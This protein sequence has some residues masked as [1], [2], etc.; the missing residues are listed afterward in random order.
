MEAVGM[1]YD[2]MNHV[3]QYK[4]ISPQLDVALEILKTTDFAALEPGSYPVNDQVY[5]NVMEP[6]VRPLENTKW[7]YHRRY[8]DIQHALVDGEQIA[9]CPTEDLKEWTPFSEKDDC[10][11]SSE[12]APCVALPTNGDNFAIFFPGDAHRPCW[13]VNGP[14]KVKKVVIK[15]LVD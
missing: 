5:Y 9:A 14:K 4:G 8:I 6:E 2:A 15:V 1:I 7:E 10:S 3:D 11:V 12:I 13:A